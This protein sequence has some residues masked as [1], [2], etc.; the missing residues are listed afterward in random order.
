MALDDVWKSADTNQIID[1]KLRCQFELPEDLSTANVSVAPSS[2]TEPSAPIDDRTF[3][4]D[5]PAPARKLL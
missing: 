2:A 5:K 4:P 1:K 3:L